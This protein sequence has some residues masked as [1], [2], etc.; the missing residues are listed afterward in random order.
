VSNLISASCWGAKNSAKNK[1]TS[2]FQYTFLGLVVGCSLKKVSC[3]PCSWFHAVILTFKK[4][5]ADYSCFDYIPH[6]H[7]VQVHTT[8]CWLP[9]DVGGRVSLCTSKLM[10]FRICH[11]RIPSHMFFVETPSTARAR[12]TTE[13]ILALRFNTTQHTSAHCFYVIYN[14]V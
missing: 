3:F 13:N 11:F 12:N 4:L 10:I 9:F 7:C 1:K 5:S 14:K 2:K 8:H 6:I